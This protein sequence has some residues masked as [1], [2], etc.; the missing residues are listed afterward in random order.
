MKEEY[1]RYEAAK[2][3]K[4]GKKAIKSCGILNAYDMLIE[5]LMKNG[6][7]PIKMNGDLFEYAAFFL[8]KLHN[9]Q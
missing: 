4:R 6:T 8:T 3:F 2:D 7:P 5:D 1:E 9:K